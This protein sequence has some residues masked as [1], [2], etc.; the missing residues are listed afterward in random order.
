MLGTA[1]KFEELIRDGI[2]EIGDGYRAKNAELGGNGLIFLRSAYLK[3]SGFV[4]D[5][6]DRFIQ[7]AVASFGPKVSEIGDVVITTKGNS[8]GRVGRI[9][10]PQSGAV[11]SPHL[12][13]WRSRRSTV[14][15]QSFLYYWSRSSE[16]ASQLRGMAHGTDMAP[17]ISLRDQQRLSISLPDI[18]VQQAI[19]QILGALDDKIELT[20]CMNETLATTSR[21]IFKD[22]FVDFGPT[23]AKSTGQPP[24]LAPEM[25][26]LF[27]DEFDDSGKPQGWLTKAL[28]EIADFL[29]GLA[30]QKYPPNGDEF[31]PVI[32]IAQ[33][34]S[35]STRSADKASVDLPT[36]YVVEDGDVLFSWSGSLMHRVWTSGRGALNQHLFKVTSQQ[37]PK[38]LLFHWIDHH[39]PAF[40]AVAAAKATTMGHIQRHHLS[41]AS[42]TLGN[43]AVMAAAE[44]LI[45]PLFDLGVANDLE[46]QTL[47]S[48]RDQLLPQLMSGEIGVR[49]AEKTVGEAL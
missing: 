28:D 34:R 29:N 4:L 33:L 43:G 39:M 35:G 18:K 30:L 49:D 2:L 41:Q 25:W 20:R 22:W 38:W 16:F 36:P 13:Y 7:T 15:D 46:A 17:Y 47:A 21:A 45:A 23:R 9:R 37:F 1:K 11:Y 31:L 48:T 12:S 19:G 26:R 44:A 24:Y 3:E 10:E 42:V 5:Q 32:K 27:P 8:T 6:P 14:L 40:R